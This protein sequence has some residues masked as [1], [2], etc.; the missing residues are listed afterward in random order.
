MRGPAIRAETAIRE[1][2]T[3]RVV[4][5]GTPRSVASLTFGE[6]LDLSLAGAARG[7]RIAH[8]LGEGWTCDL[9]LSNKIVLSSPSGEQC[10]IELVTN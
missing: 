7:R 4:T 8:A 10:L 3:G 2:I 5:I 6:A 1:A 9:Y